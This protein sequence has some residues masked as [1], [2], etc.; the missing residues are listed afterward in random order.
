MRDTAL[1]RNAAARLS[2]RGQRIECVWSG[3]ALGNARLDID[4]CL[5]WS[6]WPCGD[7]WNL[8]PSDRR[9]NQHQKRDRLPSFAT[10]A[11]ARPRI[12]AW[13]QQAWLNDPALSDRFQRE[14]A[15]ALPVEADPELDDV[16]TALEWRRLRLRQDQQV[17]EWTP[18]HLHPEATAPRKIGPAL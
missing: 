18:A 12:L 9:V 7:L 17:P 5:P 1:G 15:A 2:S 10:L 8:L 3:A 13:W 4:H 6:A 11:D 16:Y 14:V